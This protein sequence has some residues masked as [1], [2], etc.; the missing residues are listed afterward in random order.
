MKIELHANAE[1]PHV[2]VD[3]AGLKAL[4]ERTVSVSA[5]GFAGLEWPG[6]YTSGVDIYRT[7][8]GGCTCPCL[9][10]G[11]TRWTEDGRCENCGA[12]MR[13]G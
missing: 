5:A 8:R 12:S 7:D 2:L 1:P 3:A 11:P 9:V 4:R 6:M 13:D 10:C